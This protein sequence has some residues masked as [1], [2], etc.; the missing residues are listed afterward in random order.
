MSWAA[1]V[2]IVFLLSLVMNCPQLLHFESVAH[3]RCWDPGVPYVASFGSSILHLLSLGFISKRMCP[4]SWAYS[5]YKRGWEGLMSS[6]SQDDSSYHPQVRIWAHLREVEIQ[7]SSYYAKWNSTC[8]VR[9]TKIYKIV[10]A[11]KGSIFL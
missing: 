11:F 2:W 10:S 9:A 6:A 8:V 4:C 3:K 1:Q 5:R 7:L